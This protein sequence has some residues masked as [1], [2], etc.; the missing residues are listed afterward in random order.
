MVYMDIVG[1][2]K[3]V[4]LRQVIDRNCLCN[5]RRSSRRRRYFDLELNNK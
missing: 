1:F 5:R 3:L 4:I 2:T